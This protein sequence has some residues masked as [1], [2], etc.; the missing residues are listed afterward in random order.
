MKRRVVITGL[1]VIS[2]LGNDIKTFWESLCAGKSG[3]CKI[4]QFDASDYDSKIAGEVKD[5]DPALYISA[6]EIKRTDRFT[7]FAI[8][9][10]A[11]AIGDS[12]LDLSALDPW[13]FGIIVG[14]GIG[15]IHT[16]ER[17]SRVLFDKGP[18]RISPF[19]IPMLIVNMASGMIAI[20]F[21]LKG[22]NSCSVTACAS[23][24]H[25]IGEAFR[26]I[27]HGY[28]DLMLGG[29]SE[30]AINPLGIGGFCAAKA[31]SMKNQQPEKA[32][33]PFDK[34]RDG[35]VM[36]EGAG[37][38]VLEEYEH[39]KKRGANIYA[40]IIGYGM[41]CDAYHMTAPD[42]EG[43]GAIRSMQESLKDAAIKSEELTYINA[44]GTSTQLNDIMETHATKA[45]FGSHSKKIA[46]SSTKSMVGHLLGAAGGVE[47]IATVLTMKYSII[48]P[49][50]N[51]EHPDPKCDLDYVPN[52]ARKQEVKVALSNSFGFGGHNATIIIRKI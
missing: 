34:E 12:G 10:A 31:L 24:N 35:F 50:I 41:S 30:A 2:P 32:S 4:T 26:I 40:E 11:I 46:I 7:Q 48:P 28:A 52:H 44:H 22:P 3:V 29:G 14:S 15:G 42:P 51:Y 5:F 36:G 17:E 43:K 20:R 23:S 19:F 45:V 37:I 1:G 33:R 18:S 16:I 6:K 38:V 27:Q 21:G 39:A 9:A 49:T 25:S 47:L 8:G 13:R